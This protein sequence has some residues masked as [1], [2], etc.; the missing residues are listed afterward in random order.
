MNCQ[1]IS[2]AKVV[3]L[4][5]LLLLAGNALAQQGTIR[6]EHQAEQWETV[7]DDNG[8]EQVQLVKVTNVVPGDKVLF[9]VTYTNTGDQPAE[10]VAITNPVPEHMVYVDDSAAG[11]NTSI[12]FSADGGENFADA[13]DLRVSNDDGSQ[14]PA[15]ASDYTHVRWVVQSDVA[16]GTSGAVQ[17]AAVVE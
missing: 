10:N 8:A 2:I 5:G 4:S 1:A 13:S 11:D 16:P 12:L 15:N 17:F 3:L 9:T 7:T 6:L 14:R